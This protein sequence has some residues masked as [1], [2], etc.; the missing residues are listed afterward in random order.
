MRRAQTIEWS[1]VGTFFSRCTPVD[2]EARIA[3]SQG[4]ME[5]LHNSYWLSHRVLGSKAKVVYGS[6]YDIPKELGE[7]DIST[8]ACVLLHKEHPLSI[9]EEVAP[10]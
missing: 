3:D 7:F 2:L 4:G 1:I 9:L 10:G 6:A 8:V 5:T